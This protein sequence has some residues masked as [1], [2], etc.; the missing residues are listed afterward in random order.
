MRQE[1]SYTYKDFYREVAV[2]PSKT[3]KLQREELLSNIEKL[4]SQRDFWSLETLLEVT[5]HLTNEEEVDKGYTLYFILRDL[6][7]VED[8]TLNFI[9][10]FLTA[11]NRPTVRRGGKK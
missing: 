5:R 8:K 6:T 11:S 3:E 10:S 2:K 9:Q 1:E 7:R 4:Y